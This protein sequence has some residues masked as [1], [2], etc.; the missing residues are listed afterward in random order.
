MITNLAR[1]ALLPVIILASHSSVSAEAQI[2]P[3]PG[4][5]IQPIPVDNSLDPVKIALGSFL[6]SDSRLSKNSELSC[7]S[8]HQLDSGGDD[9]HSRPGHEDQEQAESDHALPCESHW[10]GFAPGG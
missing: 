5:P 6:F 7:A 10:R 4:E 2:V 1:F 8:C 9:G 3:V